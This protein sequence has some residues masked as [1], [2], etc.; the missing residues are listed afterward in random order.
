MDPQFFNL[1][2]HWWIAA[3]TGVVISLLLLLAP[4]DLTITRM[5]FQLGILVLLIQFIW[6]GTYA[7]AALLSGRPS[8]FLQ[9][10]FLSVFC[11]AA[12]TA[13]LTIFMS[14]LPQ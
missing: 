5:A 6:S 10:T 3:A 11:I 4:I 7:I 13:G 2:K 8:Y 9:L 12:L 14:R 1:R